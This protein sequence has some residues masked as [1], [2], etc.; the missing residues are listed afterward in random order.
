MP[1]VIPIADPDFA[2][3]SEGGPEEDTRGQGR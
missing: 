2:V 1:F 3:L